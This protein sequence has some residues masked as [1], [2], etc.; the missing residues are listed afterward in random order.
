MQRYM[1]KC[2]IIHQEAVS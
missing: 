1:K 2:I